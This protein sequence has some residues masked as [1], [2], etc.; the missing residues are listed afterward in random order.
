M[1]TV[2]Q[3]LCLLCVLTMGLQA[4]EIKGT[5]DELN[6]MVGPKPEQSSITGTG[7][8]KA[9]ADKVILRLNIVTEDKLLQEAIEKNN[10]LRKQLIEELTKAGLDRKQIAVAKF[11]WT[12][13]MGIFGEK[14]KKYKISNDIKVTL[15][16]EDQFIHCAVLIDRHKE[17]DYAGLSYH[18]SNHEQLKLDAL[19]KACQNATS[20]KEI[21][22]KALGVKLKPIKMTELGIENI[23]VGNLRTQTYNYLDRAAQSLSSSIPQT[24]I[25]MEQE[26][27]DENLSFGQMVFR[28]TVVV[29]YQHVP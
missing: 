28:A 18:H 8:I 2:I 27:P 20:K 29:D 14:V 22:E 10:S 9:Q 12:P 17:I 16:D 13:E 3:S 25:M 26:Q 5:P 11:S 24:M 7:V 4:T 23:K 19:E 1:R 6:L 15:T 21:Y